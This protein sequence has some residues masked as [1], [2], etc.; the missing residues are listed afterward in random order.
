MLECEAYKMGCKTKGI[1]GIPFRYIMNGH[2]VAVCKKTKRKY[3]EQQ[4]G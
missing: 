1:N 3:V 2:K 4:K